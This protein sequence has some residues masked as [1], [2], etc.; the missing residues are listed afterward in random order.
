MGRTGTGF[1]GREKELAALRE[2]A[3][4]PVVTLVRG[5]AGSGKSEV[6]S[7]L[8]T[9][10]ATQGRPALSL[11]TS[12]SMEQD[13]FGIFPLL[14]GVRERF[15]EIDAGPD[16]LAA[17][18][19]L[20]RLWTP[21]AYRAERRAALLGALA[22]LLSALGGKTAILIDDADRIPRPAVLLRL[23]R[24]AGVPV[25]VTAT[26][27][28]ARPVVEPTLEPL[29]Q[30]VIDL[31]P[32]SEDDIRTL[33]RQVGGAPA[34]PGVPSALRARLGDLLGNPGT[35]LPVLADLRSR[36]RFAVVGHHLCL[37]DPGAPIPLPDGH[38]RLER[39]RQ[40]G[41][42][43]TGLVLLA[44]SGATFGLAQL[45]AFAVATATP[46]PE[47]GRTLDRLVLDGVLSTDRSARLHVRHPALADAVIER[48][49]ADAV[50]HLHAGIA[51]AMLNDAFHG[52]PDE[53]P[54]LEHAALAGDALPV[55]PTLVE[56]ARARPRWRQ[57]VSTP[58]SARAEAIGS[59]LRSGRYEPLAKLVAGP[60]SGG[61]SATAAAGALAAIH[62]GRR[63]PLPV[64]SGPAADL[65]DRWFAGEP[66]TPADIERAFTPLT[67][68]RDGRPRLGPEMAIACA[69]RDLVP[70]LRAVLGTVYEVPATGPL[71]AFHRMCQD[72]AAGRW[73]AALSAAREV[74]L[75]GTGDPL[76]ME[77]ARLLAAEMCT[78]RGA[79][80]EAAGWLD[81]VPAHAPLGAMRGWVD[82]GRLYLA[83]DG[84]GAITAGWAAY[85]ADGGTGPGTVELLSRL[86]VIAVEQ[87]SRRVALRVLAEVEAR[88]RRELSPRSREAWALAHGLVHGV[89][90]WVR[91]S[92]SMARRRG[93]QP[94]RV[95][96]L[97]ATGL[98]TAEPRPWL[99]EGYRLA[100]TLGGTSLRAKVKRVMADR[101]VSAPSSRDRP[102][103]LSEVEQQI[104][105]LVQSG[106]SN[107]QIAATMLISEKTVEKHLTRLYLQTG[108]RTRHELAAASLGGRLERVS[109]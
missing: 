35:L 105:H 79:D 24:R 90:T 88:H 28:D 38:P 5:V 84:P 31:P 4:Q 68:E 97:L 87:G 85:R 49:G 71:A 60:G 50:R 94:D 59:L 76:G 10:L 61:D 65:C 36:G 77:F 29:A 47:C 14:A 95:W 15:E 55:Q 32:L 23:A 42:V 44:A 91:A 58:G 102:H 33:I 2:H 100:T 72:Y 13:P 73:P 52:G 108:C 83:G 27:E 17:L 1:V 86:A 41:E 22:A 3:R 40:L 45:P 98:V 21:E 89:A 93:H 51:R 16:L 66:I 19:E 6:L 37:R 92:E 109:A 63:V 67:G 43:G 106:M 8:G 78:W 20:G 104:V 34:D 54:L 57:G 107:R 25:V 81:D 103:E 9:T 7:R 18:S 80:R 96:A 30:H 53:L 74:A 75:T 46:L 62:L 82:S 11:R 26:R 69:R 39:L 101:G 48:A 70:V 99:Y 64:R 12:G 56:L